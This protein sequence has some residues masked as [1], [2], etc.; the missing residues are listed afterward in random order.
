MCKNIKKWCYYAKP[1]I[2]TEKSSSQFSGT[3]SSLIT[4]II[5]GIVEVVVVVVVLE[6]VEVV[7]VVV[8]VEV[9]EVASGIFFLTKT[10]FFGISAGFVF[11]DLFNICWSPLSKH[12]Y[13]SSQ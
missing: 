12:E 8:V 1:Y 13:G 5:V 11:L 6:V 4:G 10:F 2:N 7:V 3:I 9:L